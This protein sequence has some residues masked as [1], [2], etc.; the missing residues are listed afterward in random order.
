MYLRVGHTIEGRPIVSAD[1][2]G[3]PGRLPVERAGEHDHDPGPDR[4]VLAA[5]VEP[6]WPAA[7]PRPAQVTVQALWRWRNSATASIRKSSR[8]PC[9]QAPPILVCAPLIQPQPGRR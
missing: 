8:R 9:L 7:D 2:A 4:P 5:A 1:L 3:Q 6:L